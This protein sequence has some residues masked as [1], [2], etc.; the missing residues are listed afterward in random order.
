MSRFASSV[1][2]SSGLFATVFIDDVWSG[3]GSSYNWNS[4]SRR[5]LSHPQMWPQ[6]YHPHN[7]GTATAALI[8]AAPMFV[9]LLLLGIARKPAWMASLIGLAS[10][11]LVAVSWYGMPSGLALSSA[12]Y[13]AAFGLFPIGWIVFWA[14]L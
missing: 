11:L 4:S 13:G 3:N 9:L 14:I 7:A 6:T 2:I 8:A 5:F 1:E 10:A 12:A